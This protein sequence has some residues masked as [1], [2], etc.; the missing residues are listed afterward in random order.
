MQNLM[1]W[2]SIFSAN[3]TIGTIYFSIVMGQICLSFVISKCENISV[4]LCVK[5][6]VKYYDTWSDFILFFTFQ[7][8]NMGIMVF[9]T[10]SISAYSNDY[11]CQQQRKHQ[12]S[13]LLAFCAGDP[14]IPCYE[15]SVSMPYDHH[16]YLELLY[17]VMQLSA[18]IM[19]SD[20]SEYFIQHCN[21]SGRMCIGL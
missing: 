8:Y 7:W 15:E 21:D 19:W 1:L 11:P 6:S 5:E 9:Q 16:M 2:Q 20:W 14:P 12:S 3:I 13:K 17:L 4:S 18:V 10:A